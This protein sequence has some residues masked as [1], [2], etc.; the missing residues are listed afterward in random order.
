[1]KETSQAKQMTHPNFILGL[2][3]ILLLFIGI[4]LYRNGSESGNIIW[5]IAVGLGAIH[6]IWGITDVFRQQNLASQSRVFWQILVV[7]IPA[8][9]SMLYYMNSKTVRM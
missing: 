3:S 6:W 4:G 7:A 2:V 5:Y 1:M 9:G 8:V